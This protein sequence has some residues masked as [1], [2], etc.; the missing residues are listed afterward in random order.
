MLIKRLFIYVII[1]II[2]IIIIVI[3]SGWWRSCDG[4]DVKALKQ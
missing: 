3:M 2:I 4:E 1:I